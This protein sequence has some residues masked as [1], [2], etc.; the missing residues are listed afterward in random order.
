MKFNLQC[1]K[2]Q[3]VAGS[4]STKKNVT[5]NTCPTDCHFEVCDESVPFLLQEKGKY[6]KPRTLLFGDATMKHLLKLS[7][8]LYDA[9]GEVVTRTTNSEEAGM[10][11]CGLILVVLRRLFGCYETWQKIW[12][13]RNINK[14]KKLPDCCA[15]NALV[16]KKIKHMQNIPSTYEFGKAVPYLRAKAKLR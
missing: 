9:G 14:F 4:F 8:T 10:T 7:N 16:W 11:D 6:D 12:E 3:P 5:S 15:P 1:S 13:C 2:R